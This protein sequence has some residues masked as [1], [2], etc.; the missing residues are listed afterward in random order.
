MIF[1]P[2]RVKNFLSEHFPLLYHLAVNL[3]ARGNSPEHWDARL[4]E[5]W[6][7]PGRNW[8]VFNEMIASL[9]DPSETILDVGCGNGGTLHYLK[10]RGFRNLHGMD[11]SA[12]AVN[13]LRAEGIEMHYATLPAIPLPDGSYDVV[14][15]SFVLEH[16]IRR[17]R[18]IKEIVRVLKLA[19]RAFIF[20]PDDCLSP[21][22]EP[23]HVTTFTDRSLRKLIA[24]YLRV[25]S[26]DKVRDST[27]PAPI[28]FAQAQKQAG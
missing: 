4:A 17:R 28:L 7:D 21:I 12:Y 23:E 1:I 18:F 25:V 14:I 27:N 9:A 20:V 6:D 15:A 26:I 19:G 8:P 22:D 5:T 24:R 10:S 2:W 11:I 13:R 3:G 16:I